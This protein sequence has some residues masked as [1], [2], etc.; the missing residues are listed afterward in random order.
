MTSFVRGPNR[1]LAMRLCV[2]LIT[3]G[4][5]GC[6]PS[7]SILVPPAATAEPT[8]TGGPTAPDLPTNSGLVGSYDLTLV[9]SPTCSA[10]AEW[11]SHQIMPFPESARV[12]RYVADFTG[13]SGQ[14]TPTDGADGR[15]SIG[16]VDRYIYYGT[17]LLTVR[18]GQLTIV[19]PPDAGDI[20]RRNDALLGGP[21]SCAGGDYWWEYLSRTEVFEMCGTWRASVDDPM[22]ITGTID[23]AFGYYKGVGPN[24]TTDLFCRANNH[25]FTLTRR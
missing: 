8:A 6:S 1:S 15:I 20:S 19:V 13:A 12:R 2:L 23:G 9:A 14:L 4:S 16:G 24:W 21:P 18:D 25:R 10:V 3:V 22:R 11:D 7:H 17:N 5:S